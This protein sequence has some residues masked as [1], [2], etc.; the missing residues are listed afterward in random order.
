MNLIITAPNNG[1]KRPSVQL[2]NGETWP[3]RKDGCVGL[4]GRCR[5]THDCVNTTT[6][7]NVLTLNDF[8][9]LT[10]AQDI[11]DGIKP[12]TGQGFII[13]LKIV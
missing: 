13:N 9:T 12:I 1:R 3:N 4:D 11:A 6:F 7:C 8:K 2:S 5:Y 10:I